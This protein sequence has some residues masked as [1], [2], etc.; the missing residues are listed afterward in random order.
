MLAKDSSLIFRRW[1][2]CVERPGKSS[3]FV[4]RENSQTVSCV[5]KP[6]PMHLSIRS[7]EPLTVHMTKPNVGKS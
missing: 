6:V 3:T 7:T 2:I 5:N 4:N 1:P